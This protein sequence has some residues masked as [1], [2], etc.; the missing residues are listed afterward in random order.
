VQAQ[1]E[2]DFTHLSR[3]SLFGG[4][5]CEAFE[6]IRPL[7]HTVHYEPGEVIIHEGAV[8]DR[9]YCICKGAVEIV[10]RS[11]DRRDG[12][13]RR[14]TEMRTGDTFGEMELI[15]IQPCA[16][17]VRATEETWALTLSNHDLYRVSRTDMKTYALIMM[18][19]ARELSR[20]I[21]QMDDL[22]ARH[23]L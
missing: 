15:D 8:N 22:I 16:A 23:K 5:T 3:Y 10:K 1:P 4:I 20:R 17:T 19:L 12:A 18:N 7:I 6:V 14:I 11:V 9:I 2:I 21:R 13:M